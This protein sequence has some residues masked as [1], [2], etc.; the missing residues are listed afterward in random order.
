L[1]G[2]EIKGGIERDGILFVIEGQKAK[3]AEAEVKKWLQE[4]KML[5]P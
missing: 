5:Q 1:E 3:E 4:I 2:F